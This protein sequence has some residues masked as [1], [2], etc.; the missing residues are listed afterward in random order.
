VGV[1]IIDA[2][3]LAQKARPATVTLDEARASTSFTLLAPATLPDG[4][5]LDEV[6][7]L[8]MGGETVIQN[9]SGALA[10]SVVQTKGGAGLGDREVPAGART[11][12]VTVRGQEATLVT[13]SASE[14]GSL[15]RWQENG[16]TIVIAGTLSP[17]Q[18]QEIAASLE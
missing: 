9:Y 12:Q 13:G 14:Q 17:D 1:E 15:L 18:A 3:E 10:F 4:V 7:K 5:I 6:Q 16:V 2:A 8:G 11:E